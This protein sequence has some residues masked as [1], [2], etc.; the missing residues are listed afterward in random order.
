MDGEGH[1]VGSRYDWQM[2][3]GDIRVL[4]VFGDYDD[5]G[6][7]HGQACAEMIRK[8]TN[9]RMALT[10]SEEWSGAGVSRDLI[11]TCADETLEHHERFAEGLYA[12]MLAL[13]GAAG[14]TPQE[15]VVV[16]GFTDLI[17]VVRA[18]AGVGEE[19]NCTGF[20][21]PSLG[22]LAQTWDMHASAGEFV[23]MLKL[24]PLVGP[25]AFIQTTAGCLGQI[26]MNEAGIAIGINNLTAVGKPGVTWPFVVRKVLEQS[27]FDDAVKVVLDADLAGGHNFFLMG[28][29]GA[30]ATVEAMPRNKRLTRSDGSTLVHANS[31]LFPETRAEE[32]PRDPVWVENSETRL[33][34]G[35]MQADDLETF[36]ANP[37][38]SRRVEE[39]HDVGTCGAVVIEP[40]TRTMRAVWGVPGD[41]PWETFRL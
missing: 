28:P 21:N 40:A 26:G 27:V 38:I 11:L 6:R 29:D 1:T 5:L 4:E 31:C 35:Q 3:G 19:H 20:V 18:R 10:S 22:V 2:F 34:A 23:L 17:D 39:M 24:D 37:T 41:H 8:Y 7:G 33:R 36:F 15:A 25:D 9:D 13:A 16:G 32:G 14:I 30:A 12:E